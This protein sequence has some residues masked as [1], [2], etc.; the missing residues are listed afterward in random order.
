[1]VLSVSWVVSSERFSYTIVLLHT[2][3]VVIFVGFKFLWFRGLLKNYIHIYSDSMSQNTKPQSR[4][5]LLNYKNLNP[6]PNGRCVYQWVV[7][8][9]KLFAKPQ[10]TPVWKR[11]LC[12]SQANYFKTAFLNSKSSTVLLLDNFILH[13]PTPSHNLYS[14]SKP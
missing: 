1:M 8:V 10:N 7:Y 6:W 12:R 4:L 2:I 14:V 3:C 5:G 13:V 11:N 9:C